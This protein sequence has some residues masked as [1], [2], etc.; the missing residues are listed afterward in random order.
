MKDY[1]AKK[2]L[3]A[4]VE[5]RKEDLQDCAKAAERYAQVAASRVMQTMARTDLSEGEKAMSILSEFRSIRS[6]ADSFIARADTLVCEIRAFHM[7]VTAIEEEE[8][9]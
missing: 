4:R 2:A 6:Y 5:H 3:V 9:N 7:A 8:A 1:T